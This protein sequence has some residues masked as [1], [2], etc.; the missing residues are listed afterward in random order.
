MDDMEVANSSTSHLVE[1]PRILI[2]FSK[3]ELKAYLLLL[4]LSDLQH[5]PNFNSK[6]FIAIG[7]FWGNTLTKQ[8]KHEQKQQQ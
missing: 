7:L 4:V 2:L 1:N 5:N 8:L 3:V 6:I